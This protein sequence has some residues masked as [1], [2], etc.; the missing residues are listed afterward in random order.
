M[1]I[2]AATRTLTDLSFT[3]F[4]MAS[5]NP[6]LG[7][8]LKGSDNRVPSGV[9]WGIHNGVPFK[10]TLGF[11]RGFPL[12]GFG[13]RFNLGVSVFRVSGLAFPACSKINRILALT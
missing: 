13:T 9:L 1:S 3:G 2:F 11:Y 8:A 5:L 6:C 4:F 7:D 10:G 12:R